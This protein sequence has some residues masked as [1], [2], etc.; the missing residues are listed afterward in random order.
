MINTDKAER[1]RKHENS[2]DLVRVE[3]QLGCSLES[4]ISVSFLIDAA[5]ILCPPALILGLNLKGRAGFSRSELLCPREVPTM[6]VLFAQGEVS[7]RMS[8]EVL[9]SVHRFLS[10]PSR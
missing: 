5:Q 9:H 1:E 2:L 10:D 8:W 6:G 4:S 3:C 7:E